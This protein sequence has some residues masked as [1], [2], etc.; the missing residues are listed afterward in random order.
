[1]KAIYAEGIDAAVRSQRFIKCVHSEI[2][3]EFEARLTDKARKDGVRVQ[4]EAPVHGSFK[5][6]NVDVAVIH[7]VNGPLILVGVRSQMSSVSKNILTY[8]Q[9]IMGESVSLQDRFPM[10]VFAYAYLLPLRP[11]DT[12]TLDVD[13]YARLFGNLTGRSGATYKQERGRY[14]HFAFAVVDFDADPPILMEDL[15]K[16]SNPVVDLSLEKLTDNIIETFKLRNP[17]LDYFN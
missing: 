13:R 17:W 4:L 11:K 12:G 14:D 2:A 8:I 3:S 6:K 16:K 1:M 15:V 9:D 10:S 5:D 7:P